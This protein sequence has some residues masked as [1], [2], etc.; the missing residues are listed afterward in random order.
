MML[1]VLKTNQVLCGHVPYHNLSNNEV[2]I[3]AIIEGDRPRKPD[4][5]THLGF[6]EELWDTVKQCWLEDWRAR[7]GVEEIL[8]SL[9]GAPPVPSRPTRRRVIVRRA[10]SVFLGDS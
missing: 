3:L 1:E 2:V 8:S 6:T 4:N 10:I 7:P 5:V 9:N